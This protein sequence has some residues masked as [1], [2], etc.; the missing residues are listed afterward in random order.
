MVITMVKLFAAVA[1]IA[2]LSAVAANLEILSPGG[3]DE[4]WGKL[5]FSQ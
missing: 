5:E 3:S 2:S 1:S 4:W